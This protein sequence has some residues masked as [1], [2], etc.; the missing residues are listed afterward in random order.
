MEVAPIIIRG[1]GITLP[2]KASKIAPNTT[3]NKIIPSIEI[4]NLTAHTSDGS[5]F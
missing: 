2:S 1:S 4:V 5:G 3:E